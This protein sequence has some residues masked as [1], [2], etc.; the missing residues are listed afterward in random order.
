MSIWLIAADGD[1]RTLL[2][3]VADDAGVTAV[4]LDPDEAERLL[5]PD[6]LPDAVLVPRSDI[7][8]ALRAHLA[9]ISRLAVATTHPEGE[10][11]MEDGA[12]LRVV[13]PAEFDEL[14]RA[15][16]WLAWDGALI[17]QSASSAPSSSR[18]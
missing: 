9:R 16:R 18:V 12:A 5:D 15:V 2:A 10:A 3:S 11:D 1:L 6:D 4:A 7:H 8:P 17:P 14:D 13:L